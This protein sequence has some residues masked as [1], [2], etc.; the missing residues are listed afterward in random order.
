MK[1]PARSTQQTLPSSHSRRDLLGTAGG[2]LAAMICGFD[3]NAT[4]PPDASPFPVTGESDPKLA[5]YD[6]LMT[7]FMAKYDPPGAALAVTKDGRLVYARGFGYADMERKEPVQP[8]SLFR[9]ASLSKAFTSTAIFQLVEQGKL[10]LDDRV[11]AVIKLQPFLERGARLDPR[12]YGVTVTQCLQH[13]GV[14]DRD[15]GF[16]PMGAAAAER[17]AQAMGLRLPIQPEHI[18]RYT[19]GK[20]LNTSPGSTYAYSNFGY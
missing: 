18:I 16:D 11:F 4:A 3:A 13:T 1:T 14:W 19:M 2:G 10:K 9:I 20:P 12:I 6:K 8:A 5:A 17:V 15:K 7:D